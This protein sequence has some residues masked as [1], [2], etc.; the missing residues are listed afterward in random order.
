MHWRFSEQPPSLGDYMKLMA[1]TGWQ[2]MLEKQPD[3]FQAALNNSWYM[4]NAYDE[5][6]LIGSGRVLSD[7]VFH[8]LLCDLI[9]LPEY[10]GQGLGSAILKQLLK[11]CEEHQIVMVQLFAASG[12]T[13]F[14]HSFGFEARPSDAPG[15][16]WVNKTHIE[17]R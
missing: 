3:A 15:M 9:V 16:R 7:G 8:A 14:Y 10:Q 6:E 17:H 12:K 1:S 11:R 4:L 13:S 2:G 5:S